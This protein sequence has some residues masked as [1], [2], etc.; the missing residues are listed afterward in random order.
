MLAP[1][2]AVF[3]L[4]LVITGIAKVNRPRD[5]EKAL[6]SLR[7]PRVRGAGLIIGVAEIVVG[8]TALFLPIMLMTQGLLYAG[9]AIWVF[10]ALRSG[11]PL[12]SCGCLG[13][14]DTPPTVA[15]ITLN[16]IGALVSSFAAVAGQ[17]LELTIG[18]G[19]VASVGA[20]LVAV[21]LSYVVLTDAAVLSGVRRR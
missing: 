16:V 4:L 5:V 2:A 6:A 19:G 17:S 11:A 10:A 9:F 13:R 15:H 12:T 20:I 1:T 18:F 14:D 7:L 8:L 3:S 21:F